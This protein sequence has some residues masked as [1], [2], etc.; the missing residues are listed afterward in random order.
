MTPILACFSPIDVLTNTLTPSELKESFN[1][2][3]EVRLFVFGTNADPRKLAS[4][5]ILDNI[6]GFIKEATAP[7]EDG[8]K[9]ANLNNINLTELLDA[10]VE[11]HAITVDNGVIHHK[12]AETP[13]NVEYLTESKALQQSYSHNH[14]R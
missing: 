12:S 1:V 8:L 9:L 14:T 2:E 7:H 11:A 10:L 5:K 13:I 6:E 4:E 3:S